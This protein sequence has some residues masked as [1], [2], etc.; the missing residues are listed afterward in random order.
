MPS[1]GVPDRDGYSKFNDNSVN[2]DDSFY[3]PTLGNTWRNNCEDV[4]NEIG[5]RSSLN[6]DCLIQEGLQTSVTNVEMHWNMNYH[7]AAIYLELPVG[8][9]GTVEL[10]ALSVIGIELAMKLRWIGWTAL[11]KHKR[12]MLKLSVRVPSNPFV[13]VQPKVVDMVGGR[14]RDIVKLNGGDRIVV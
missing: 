14:N 3:S 13:D 5:S 2:I 11:L 8:V 6:R 1:T 10:V 12:T 9:H 7:E 4:P